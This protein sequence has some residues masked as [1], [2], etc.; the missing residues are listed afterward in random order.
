ME[1]K[2][3]KNI[4][5]A[6]AQDKIGSLLA[7]E[8]IRLGE[9]VYKMN[10]G[11]E[12]VC[13]SLDGP[14]DIWYPSDIL[15]GAFILAC[16]PDKAKWPLGEDE[17]NGMIKYKVVGDAEGPYAV[18]WEDDYGIYYSASIKNY[19]QLQKWMLMKAAFKCDIQP[20]KKDRSDNQIEE[21]WIGEPP[22]YPNTAKNS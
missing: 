5:I 11:G 1:F 4:A 10:E 2:I 14:K 19:G 15:S 8:V 9:M 13:R 12:L 3:S 18:T 20:D 22:S 6:F 16:L 21:C 7:G 17:D